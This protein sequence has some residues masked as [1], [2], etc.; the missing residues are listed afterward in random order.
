MN[1]FGRRRKKYPA[2]IA[3]DEIFLDS[4]NLPE[5]DTDQ[6]E[7]RM[8]KPISR[9]AIF[10]LS[11]VFLLVGLGY[12]FRIVQL[13]VVSGEE[14]RVQSEENR[15]QHKIFFADR[16]IIYDRNGEFLAWNEPG[17]FGEEFNRRQYIERG[18][19]SNILG[20][21]KPPQKDRSGFY[22]QEAYIGQDGLEKYFD[23]RLSGENGLQLIETNAL[24]ELSSESVVRHPK[25]GKSVY[26]SID[27]R[28]QGALFDAV[29]NV[30]VNGDFSGGGGIIMDVETGEVIAAVTYPEYD[31]NLMTKGEDKELIQELFES[32]DNP[33]LHRAID[34]LY[35]PGSTVKP[36]MAYGALKEGV[37]TPETEILSTGSITIPN[38]YFPDQPS[39]F[40]D[41][42]AHGLVNLEEALAYS[43]NVYFYTIGG[44]FEGQKGIGIRKID[45][46]MRLFGFGSPVPGDF[47]DSVEGVV[48]NPEWKEEVFDNDPWRIGDT[49]YTSIGQYGFQT[50]ALQVA[51]AISALA[52]GG[53]LL[54]PQLTLEDEVEVE[55]EIPFDGRDIEAIHRGLRGTVEYGTSKA[56]NFP[57]VEIAAKTGTAE[58]GISKTRINSWIS[59]FF[60]YDDP[61]YAFALV[62]EKGPS[63]F[64]IGV[65]TA[66]L[67]FFNTVNEEAPEYFK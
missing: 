55:R 56:L 29:E 13:Q 19:F 31:S 38:P 1:I 41:N 20:Y 26:T 27:S 65:N 64:Q 53:K 37:V 3:P 51:R 46:Y 57:F 18:G 21:V 2:D 8:E 45:E 12:F 24:N 40:R 30:S 10:V 25:H 49:Y 42:K 22:F 4:S 67:Q 52:N 39:I 48:P 15:L 43:S 36:Y 28:I 11:T 59:G 33:F 54:V 62:L 60:P 44:G 61:K 58:T 34:G 7:G 17:E 63:D 9:Q 66:M 23:E 14:Y 5:Y 16:G 32:E 50:T 6:F 35:T 47:F